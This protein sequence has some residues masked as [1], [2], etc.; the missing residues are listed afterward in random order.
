MLINSVGQEI[1]CSIAVMSCICYVMSGVS[2][3]NTQMV[4]GLKSSG[5]IFTPIFGAWLGWL[6][7]AGLLTRALACEL[8]VQLGL[9]AVWILRKSKQRASVPREWCSERSSW[10]FLTLYQLSL[11]GPR[12]K[13]RGN[14]VRLLLSCWGCGEFTLKKSMSDGRYYAPSWPSLECSICHALACNNKV[15]FLPLQGL[16]WIQAILQSRCPVGWATQAAASIL[17][18]L[19]ISSWFHTHCCRGRAAMVIT[20]QLSDASSWNGHHG[21][22]GHA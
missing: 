5:S 9:C 10:P 2:V 15:R 11:L 20:Y 21:S 17:Q 3:G 14:R 18:L 4:W 1:R 19:C 12:S 13:G 16:L 7:L 22:H 8:S 6:R